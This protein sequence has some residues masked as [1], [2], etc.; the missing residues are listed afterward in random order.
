M[1]RPLVLLTILL[2]MFT[3]LSACVKPFEAPTPSPEAT[4][5]ITQTPSPSAT[6]SS[7]PT[8]TPTPLPGDMTQTFIL[9]MDDNGYSHL[10]AYAPLKMAPV[11][12]TNGLWDD[13]T[14]AIN[15][16]GSKVIFA[17][18]RNAYWDL[19]ILNL[20]DGQITRMTDTPEF[21]GNPAWS[22]DGQW[23]TYETMLGDQM[24]IN[25]LSAVDPGQIIQLTNDP[26]FDQD[27]VWSPLGREV[28]FVSNR[29]GDNEIWIA[30]LD[31]P[32]EGRFVNVSQAPES[33]D[34]RPAWSF[35]G[36]KLAWAVR[37]NAQPD[38]IY[39]WDSNQP[40]Q[41]PRRAGSGDWP[42]WSASGNEIATR[43]VSPNQDYL[44]AYSLDGTLSL[45]PVPIKGIRGMDW[46][47]ERVT[48][49]P[50]VFYKQ[51]L[52]TP[53]L[54]WQRQVQLIDDIPGKR[55]SIIKLLDVDAPHPYLHDAVNES[56]LALRQRIIAETGWDVLA[57][58]ENAYTP[59][60]SALDPGKGQDWLFT[61][62]A[63][64]INPLTLNA[65][66][67]VVVREEIDGRTYWRIFLRTVAQDGSQGEPMR[68][69]P[70][71]LSSRYNLDPSTY[72]QGGTYASSIPTGFWVDLTATAQKFGWERIPA[73]D[74]WR[75]YFK[76][77]QFNQF[78]LSDGLDWR[79][80]ML[81][82][83]P[84]DIFVTPTVIIPPTRTPT[85]TPKGYRFKTA[86]PTVTS[87][88][89]MRP[90]FTTEP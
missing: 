63:F 43:L 78:I 61:G 83:Y 7:T 14:P 68:V 90:T 57:S 15:N 89:T 45:P 54:L 38:A 8:K 64:A 59:L 60:T 82:L 55:L 62:R 86:T 36:S 46:H 37:T 49:L 35:D 42:A 77:T 22:P 51:A 58:L 2:I 71:D 53:T 3:L 25:I 66:W 4:N 29:S 80:A 32:D 75:S 50:N 39:L 52:L 17:S 16:D 73:F 28:A 6:V 84:V 27:P 41:P 11:R 79:A 12:L 44:V 1:N 10:F 21:D 19:Y 30:N 88:P 74:N 31:K 40:E 34:I 33:A 26:S 47:L 18:N 13:V 69:L 81:E 20:I 23:I 9:S 76:G 48:S 87:T 67:M 70:W 56:F 5:T 24:E 72:D 65:G 85:A